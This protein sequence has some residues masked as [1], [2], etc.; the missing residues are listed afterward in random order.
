MDCPL[1]LGVEQLMV[2]GADSATNVQQHGV[3]CPDFVQ[4]LAECLDE[5]PGGFVR[6]VLPKPI[7]ALAGFPFIELGFDSVALIARQRKCSGQD[8]RYET[9][10]SKLTE[11]VTR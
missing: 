3:A 4:R 6:T 10:F 2:N 9:T 1:D 11:A 8:V 5:Q 7:Q